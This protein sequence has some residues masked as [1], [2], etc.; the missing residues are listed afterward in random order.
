[1]IDGMKNIVAFVTIVDRERGQKREGNATAG[2]T[3]YYMAAF[4]RAGAC[5]AGAACDNLTTPS[6]KLDIAEILA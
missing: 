3:R 4:Q 1:M 2:F 6:L 5:F